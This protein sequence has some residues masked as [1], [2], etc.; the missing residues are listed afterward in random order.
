M[1]L[2]LNTCQGRFCV[3]PDT[4]T[5]IIYGIPKPYIHS[6][7]FEQAGIQLFL[8]GRLLQGCRE[9]QEGP[10]ETGQSSRPGLKEL[11]ELLCFALVA[12]RA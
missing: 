8:A 1:R 4:S 11:R 9:E 3:Q 12:S 2:S 7:A 6:E 10:G 5:Q